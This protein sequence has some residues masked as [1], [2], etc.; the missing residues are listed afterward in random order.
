MCGEQ[1]S[2]FAVRAAARSFASYLSSSLFLGV[3]PTP[4]DGSSVTAAMQRAYLY[5]TMTKRCIK[6]KNT[7][8][9]RTGITRPLVRLLYSL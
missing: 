3:L 7:T 2:G 8:A 4:R 6:V 9:T 5:P 1:A